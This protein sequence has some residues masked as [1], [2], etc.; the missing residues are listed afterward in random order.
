MGGWVVFPLV[1]YLPPSLPPLLDLPLQ[2][3]T[4]PRGLGPVAYP[5]G[6]VAPAGL[7][8]GIPRQPD[9]RARP[10]D[11]LSGF[12]PRQLLDPGRRGSRW[13]DLEAVMRNTE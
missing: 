8:A 7:R 13:R 2:P 4:G 5:A 1:S 10:V 9:I 12:L 3:E 6:D 11:L